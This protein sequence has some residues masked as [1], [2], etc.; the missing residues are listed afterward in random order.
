MRVPGDAGPR[1]MADHRTEHA[2]PATARL[3]PELDGGRGAG[4]AVGAGSVLDDRYRLDSLVGLGGT[5]TVYRAT[6]LLL[7]RQVAVKVFHPH[8]TDPAMVARQRQEMQIVAGLRHPNLILLHDARTG[9]AGS[10][11]AYLVL[12]FVDGPTLGERLQGPPLTPAEVAHI[13]SGV[14]AALQA[15]HARGLVHRDVKPGNIL[16]TG[17]GDAKLSDFGIARMLDADRVTNSADVVGTAPYLSPE[18]ASS[19]DVGPAADIYALGLVLLEC[20]KGHR[21]YP[22]PAVE[23]AV[24]RLLRDPAVPPNLPAGWPALLASMTA[25]E[26]ADRPAADDVVAALRALER[27]PGPPTLLA[28]DPVQPRRRRRSVLVAVGAAV[29][30]TGLTTAGVLLSTDPPPAE[31]PPGAGAPA[32]SSALP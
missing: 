31:S 15:M 5:A 22:G 16:L 18:Q 9:S 28:G 10:G 20:L 3:E 25:F 23:S 4:Q 13:G 32:V 30:V 19:A 2:L 7:D 27:P 12:E 21:E 29:L 26:S 14:A 24:A 8:F 6:D 1:A 17:D 11:L